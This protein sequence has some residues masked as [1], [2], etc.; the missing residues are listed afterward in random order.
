[1]KRTKWII[2]IGLVLII[3]GL[4][5]GCKKPVKKYNIENV[6]I[7]GAEFSLLLDENVNERVI[8]I[9]L[10]FEYQILPK[11]VNCSV[12]NF[13]GTHT[14]GLNVACSKI[15]FG[16]NRDTKYLLPCIDVSIKYEGSG[17]FE[18]KEIDT[19]TFNVADNL[20]EADVRILVKDRAA[21]G[22]Y[23]NLDMYTSENKGYVNVAAVD[24][25]DGVII[26]A[27]EDVTIQSIRYMDDVEMQDFA[28]STINDDT[29]TAT[30]ISNNNIDTNITIHSGEKFEA[31]WKLP[32][33][34]DCSF[35]GTEV[36]V[37]YLYKGQT[38][39]DSYITSMCYPEI[40]DS[41]V[42]KL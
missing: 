41:I 17:R 33:K 13:K 5:V 7:P 9:P 23:R 29:Q 24:Y 37:E 39:I 19:I 11:D 16:L 2:C 26:I 31:I 30:L 21:Y 8:R 42:S 4:C 38:Y 28:F 27:N 14:E 35:F 36:V 15:S 1:M 10:L 18:S 12:V 20:I 34:E 22:V 32:Q 40:M 3:V 25:R 6:P